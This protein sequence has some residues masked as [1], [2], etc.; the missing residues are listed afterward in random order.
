MKQ[1]KKLMCFSLVTL[2]ILA[3]YSF[4]LAETTA[5]GDIETEEKAPDFRN[6]YWGDSFDIVIAIETA[7]YNPDGT[8]A[9][10]PSEQAN[11][12][13]VLYN[14]TLANRD[15]II[16]YQFDADEVLY[17]GYYGIQG[18]AATQAEYDFFKELLVEKY[19]KP[20]DEENWKFNGFPAQKTEW[21]TE[22][23]EIML[24][25]AKQNFVDWVMIMYTSL[26]IKPSVDASGL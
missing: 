1:L 24:L 6:S 26:D 3:G 21:N 13:Q 7:K 2:L 25:F 19:G 14:G 18:N 23:S 8:T 10:E 17:Q 15:V 22:K 4:C 16:M 12:T 5:S 9:K 11:R 20:Y